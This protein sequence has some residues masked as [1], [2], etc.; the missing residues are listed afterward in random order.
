M[1]DSSLTLVIHTT[2]AR[3]MLNLVCLCPIVLFVFSS[4]NKIYILCFVQLL[5]LR[6]CVCTKNFILN[7]STNGEL[8]FLY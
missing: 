2:L 8:I 4:N 6:F 7:Y 5:L 1:H 3:L